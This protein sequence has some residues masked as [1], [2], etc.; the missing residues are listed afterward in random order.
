VLQDEFVWDLAD[1]PRL[2][3]DELVQQVACGGLHSCAVWGVA[4]QVLCWG[5]NKRKQVKVPAPYIEYRVAEVTLG[6][7]H[8]C[9]MFD[10]GD[11]KCWGD[12]SNG[13]LN[14]E[15]PEIMSYQQ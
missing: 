2:V 9:V 5:S 10:G 7:N 11:A 8:T 6:N 14:V 13:Q 15:L 1:V 4:N 3:L 12:A